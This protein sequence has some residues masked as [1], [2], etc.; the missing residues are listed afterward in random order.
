MVRDVRVLS[1]NSLGLGH[2]LCIEGSMM[3]FGGSGVFRAYSN[4]RFDVDKYRLPFQ[5]LGMSECSNDSLDI[6]A[7]I[8]NL[9]NMP[10]AR[11]HLGVDILCVYPIQRTIASNLVVVVKKHEVIQF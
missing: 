4:D 3:G 9:K 2:A 6:I 11:S 5:C 8:G 7:S 10:T 1:G